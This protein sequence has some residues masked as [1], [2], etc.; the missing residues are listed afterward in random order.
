V[1]FGCVVDPESGE[2][3]RVIEEYVAV[4]G[5][6]LMEV[7]EDSAIAFG[8]PCLCPPVF[9]HLV[10]RLKAHDHVLVRSFGNV[11]T[12]PRATL[13]SFSFLRD[14]G[15]TLH[16]AQFSSEIVPESEGSLVVQGE[17]GLAVQTA[18]RMAVELDSTFRSEAIRKA[19]VEREAA[20]RKHCRNAA[21]IGFKWVRGKLVLD[22]EGQEVIR[23][24]CKLRDVEGLSWYQIAKR[25]TLIEKRGDWS[26]TRVRTWCKAGRSA[27]PCGS[28]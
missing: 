13:E 7:F 11:Y 1:I 12:R 20:G 17:V 21:P 3:R 23:L 5:L 22:P 10:A 6:D 16:I 15:L 18:F 25:L 28:A 26:P 24:I 19:L 2:G 14:W 4:R 27:Q 8:T 9:Q